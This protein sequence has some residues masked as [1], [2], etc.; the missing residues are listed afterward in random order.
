MFLKDTVRGIAAYWAA[1]KLLTRQGWWKYALAPGFVSLIFAGVVLAAAWS[2]SDNIGNTLMLLYP[3]EAGRA[4]AMLVATLLGS[5]LIIAVGIIIFKN[6]V[7]LLVSPWMNKL[8]LK[9]ERQ[10]TGRDYVDDRTFVVAFRRQL[11]LNLRIILRE[12]CFIILVFLVG[13]I[14]IVDF[15]VPLLLFLVQSFYAGFGNLDYFM[16]RHYTFAESVDFVKRNRGVALGNGIGFLLLLL[17]PVIGVFLAPTLGVAAATLSGIE[18]QEN[19][20]QK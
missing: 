17:I 5:L 4:A 2:L 11:R 7:M 3:F 16:D 12:I 14:P 20:D 19:G 15:A 18:L 10:A 9:I 6:L 1:I 8:S 13:L